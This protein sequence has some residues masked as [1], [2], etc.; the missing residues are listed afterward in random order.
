MFIMKLKNVIYDL[1][2][3]SKVIHALFTPILRLI[4]KRRRA[5]NVEYHAR[6]ETFNKNAEESL[7][8]FKKALDKEGLF[9]WL[10]SGTLL[11]AYRE[12]QL[13][14]HDI[15][16]DVAMFADDAQKV[17]RI[18]ETGDFVLVHGFGIV[19]EDISELSFKCRDVKIDIFFAK[20][21]NDKFVTTVLFKDRET[22]KKDD[23]RV[24]E[25]FLPETDFIEYDFLGDKYMIP[26]KTKEYLSANYGPNFMTPDKHWDYT[27]DIPSAI[28]YPISEKQ[29]YIV[30]Y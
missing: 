11:G 29:G 25:M 10:T 9:F 21:V 3:N 27:R 13:L 16:L 22:D 24:I 2:R 26:R 12:H 6:N 7:R 19:G 18:L 14:K 4:A 15:D 28:Y 17:K 5:T 20:K 8:I 23:F 30:E 1:M